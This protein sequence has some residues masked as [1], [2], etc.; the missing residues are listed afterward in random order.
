MLM[1]N[2][3]FSEYIVNYQSVNASFYGKH[4]VQLRPSA[5]LSGGHKP[6]LVSHL[7]QTTK[8]SL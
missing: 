1:H 6:G 5:M 8:N 7:S 3:M 2:D 4:K